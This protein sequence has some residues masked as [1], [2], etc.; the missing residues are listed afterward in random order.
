MK[1]AGTRARDEISGVGA[2]AHGAQPAGRQRPDLGDA[3]HQ[4]VI[5]LER[6]LDLGAHQ[7]VHAEFGQ[8]GRLVHFG[9]VLD[10]EYVRDRVQRAHA[11]RAVAAGLLVV[12]QHHGREHGGPELEERV[13]RDQTRRHALRQRAAD[14]RVVA[15]HRLGN[16]T[17]VAD[18]APLNGQLR[19]EQTTFRLGGDR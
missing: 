19:V 5:P 8:R 11:P 3:Q 13:E 6:L 1:A 2:A 18:G 4:V 15:A 10:A 14:H 12:G 17:D 16:Q 7:R 9:R